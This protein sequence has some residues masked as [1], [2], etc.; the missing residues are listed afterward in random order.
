QPTTAATEGVTEGTVAKT[1]AT[2]GTQPT[3][4]ATEGVSEGTVAKTHATETT[5]KGTQSTS[6]ATEEVT[7]AT[8]PKTV[9]ADGTTEEPKPITV[10]NEGISE[11]AVGGT[12]ATCGLTSV[13]ASTSAA[14]ISGTMELCMQTEYIAF[15]VG[16]KSISTEPEDVGDFAGFMRDGVNFT[17]R[18]PVIVITM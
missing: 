12:D 11:G 13:G 5:T 15:L 16:A 3:S 1:L 9:A 6:A 18:N 2:E 8:V 14:V 17:E 10:G 4:A 7:E